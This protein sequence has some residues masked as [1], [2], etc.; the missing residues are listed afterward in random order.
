MG[1]DVFAVRPRTLPVPD[2]IDPYDENLNWDVVPE[3]EVFDPLGQEERPFSPSPVLRTL[4]GFRGAYYENAVQL[5]CNNTL[6]NVYGPA[7]VQQLVASIEHYVNA[8]GEKDP[9][10]EDRLRG[11]LPFLRLAVAAKCWLYPYA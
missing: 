6:Y 3:A 7:D 8:T 10:V 1:L 4:S 5:A 9:D 11:L 2:F